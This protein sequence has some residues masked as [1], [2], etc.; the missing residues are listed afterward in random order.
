MEGASSQAWGDLGELL[1]CACPVWSCCD[2]R[3][4]LTWM[5]AESHTLPLVAWPEDGHSS[6]Q[7]AWAQTAQQCDQGQV[8]QPGGS[9]S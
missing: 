1:P 2:L 4:T 6:P 8:L 5:Q 3:F 7:A 9:S